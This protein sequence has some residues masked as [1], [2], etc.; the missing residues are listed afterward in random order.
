MRL[1]VDVGGTFIKAGVVGEDNRIIEKI[2][3]P[4]ENEKGYQ[5]VVKNIARAANLAAEKVGKK[6]SDFPS[7]GFGIPGA[8]NPKTGVVVLCPN[9]GGWHNVPFLEE[10]KKHIFIPVAVGNDANCAVVGE[11]IAGAAAGCSDVVMLT[12]GTGIG[13]GVIAEGRMLCGGDGLGIE[14]GHIPLL[15]NGDPCGCGQRGCIETYC[16]VTALVRQTKKAMALHGDSL[17]HGYAQKAGLVDGR[18]SFECAKLGDKTALQVVDVYTDYL[19]QAIGAFVTIF[20]PD[21]VLIGGGLS[22]QGAYLLD[23]LNEKVKTRVFAYDVI[24]A[25]PIRR[26]TLGNDAGTIGAAYLETL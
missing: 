5:G 9:L 8:V 26:A 13:G 22:N 25:P 11:N 23:M 21:V 10:I 4:T 14:L 17:M 20:R 2:S 15:H 24:G 12:L 16:S 7:V 6:L 19:A 1:G 3:V 18:T